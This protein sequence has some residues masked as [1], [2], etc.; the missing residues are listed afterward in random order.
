VVK[1]F[2]AREQ[3]FLIGRAVLGLLNNAGVLS[4]LSMEETAHFFAAAVQVVVPSFTGLGRPS[5]ELVRTLR[6]QLSRRNLR[7]LGPA[8]RAVAASSSVALSTTL[9]ALAAAANRAGML[10]AAD[11]AVALHLVLREDPNVSGIRPDTAD[12]VLQAVRERS[13]LRSLIAFA[14]SDNF[15]HLRREVGLALPEKTP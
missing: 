10:M 1:K 8:A 11:P 14:L 3:K 6:K 15:F 13:D 5:E 2:N 7:A 12:P 4:R 9:S